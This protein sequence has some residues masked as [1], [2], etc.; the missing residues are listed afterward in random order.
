[1]DEVFNWLNRAYEERDGRFASLHVD[2]IFDPLRS[3]PRFEEL[4]RRVGLPPRVAE[5]GR[6]YSS[7]IE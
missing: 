4:L 2:P 5:A 3:D 7:S 1:M 6:G